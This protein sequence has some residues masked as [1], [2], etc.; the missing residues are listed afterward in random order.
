MLQMKSFFVQKASYKTALFLE[1][2]NFAIPKTVEEGA[3]ENAAE[4]LTLL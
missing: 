2:G 4:K 1:L 3:H